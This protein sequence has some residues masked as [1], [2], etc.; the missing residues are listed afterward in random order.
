MTTMYVPLP[1]DASP[2]Y[3]YSVSL[4][5]N[6]YA[7]EF[8]YNTRMKLY[9][10]NLYDADKA[11]VVLGQA[12]V[13]NSPLLVGYSIP[14]LSGFFVLTEKGT[15]LVEAYKQY[16]ESISTYYDFLYIYSEE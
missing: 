11:P 2:F 16:P 8:V 12:L 3:S 5:G 15:T 14:S 1:L 10:F 4:Q 13:P 6:S 7:L 9:V